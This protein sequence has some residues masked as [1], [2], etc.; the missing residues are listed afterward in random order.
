MFII[1]KFYLFI[2][3]FFLVIILFNFCKNF[4]V[5]FRSSFFLEFVFFYISRKGNMIWFKYRCFINRKN[6]VFFKLKKRLNVYDFKS[7]LFL[8]V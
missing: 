7:I 1:L 4:L 5:V 3:N 6:F 8:F 2:Y